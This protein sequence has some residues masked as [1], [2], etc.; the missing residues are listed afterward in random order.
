MP[1][2]T[3][4]LDGQSRTAVVSTEEVADWVTRREARGARIEQIAFHPTERAAVVLATTTDDPVGE[5]D[6]MRSDLAM[7]RVIEDL[8]QALQTKG[9]LSETDLPE[10]AREKI[11]TRDDLRR[12][13]S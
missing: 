4:N 12:V 3:Y 2:I 5:L 11:A 6:L 8:F 9:V 10:A 13:L 7:A 1:V